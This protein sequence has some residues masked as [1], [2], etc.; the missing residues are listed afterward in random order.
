MDLFQTIKAAQRFIYITGW[1]VYTKI[2][3]VRGD[4]DTGESGSIHFKLGS[5]Y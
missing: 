3:L 2:N 5:M 1:S 4:D